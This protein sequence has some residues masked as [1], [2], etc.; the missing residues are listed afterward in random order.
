MRLRPQLRHVGLLALLVGAVGLAVPLSLLLSDRWIEKVAAPHVGHGVESVPVRDVVIVLGARVMPDGS[1]SVPLRDRLQ[2]ALELYQAGRVRWILVSGDNGRPGYD[3]VNTM[4]TWLV[5]R[6]VPVED[7]YLDHAGFRTF[8]SM[9]RAK[10]VFG[11]RS[12]I[13]STQG[14]HLP[15][16]VFLARQ[17]GI[18]AVGVS[19]DRRDYP[20]ADRDARRERFARTKAALDILNP[21]ASPHHLGP[22]IRIGQTSATASHDGRSAR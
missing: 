6:G 14:F 3:E 19:A 1:V 18:D 16:A 8:D 22:A 21:F 4:Q 5:E 13:I 10:E 7:V 15:R 20:L 9:V 2:N 17:V 12:A 11:V